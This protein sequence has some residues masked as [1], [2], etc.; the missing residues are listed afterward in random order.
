MIG[1][2]ETDRLRL[3]PLATCDVLERCGLRY[4]RTFNLDWPEAIEGTE[5]GDVEYEILRANWA[6]LRARPS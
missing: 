3:R 4:V 2:F 5:H 1:S 6:D